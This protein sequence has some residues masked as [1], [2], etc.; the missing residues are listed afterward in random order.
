[1]NLARRPYIG[2]PGIMTGEEV[3]KIL[4][5]Y[6]LGYSHLLMVEAHMNK[7]ALS[8]AFEDER[9]KLRFPDPRKLASIFIPDARLLNVV[10][11][12]SDD[13]DPTSMY[14]DL[15]QIR[16]LA[17]PHLG[18]FVLDM[19]Q[20]HP[21]VIARYLD[22]MDPKMRFILRIDAKTL[23]RFRKSTQPFESFLEWHL[24][25]ITDILIDPVE[26]PRLPFNPVFAGQLFVWLAKHCETVR[27]GITGAAA[28]GVMSAVAD[29]LCLYPN[30]A[31]TAGKRLR[32]KNNQLSFEKVKK[33]LDESHALLAAR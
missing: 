2:I 14:E 7:R 23:E 22:H 1:L 31:V 17:G 6:G 33:F 25:N 16:N 4:A 27:V 5:V 8:G 10:R 28:N 3:R 32:D 26:Q 21:H 13:P 15:L 29:L 18:G 20:A 9:A 30:L 19:E 24:S 11:Y 12:E